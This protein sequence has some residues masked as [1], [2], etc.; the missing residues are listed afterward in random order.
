VLVGAGE[1]GKALA[2]HEGVDGVLFTGSSHTGLALSRRLA[3]QPGKIVALD[4]GGNNPIVVWDTPKIADAAALVVQSAFT[5][6]GSGPLP[7]GG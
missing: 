5:T 1:E 4:L 3:A 7:R 6:A 2:A